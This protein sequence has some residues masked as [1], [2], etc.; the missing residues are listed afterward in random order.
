MKITRL[1]WA[2]LFAMSFSCAEQPSGSKD[3]MDL[4]AADLGRV[5]VGKSAPDFTLLSKDNEAVTL[6]SFEGKNNVV[7]VFYRGYW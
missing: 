5:S 1:F 7:L 3:G 2:L 4:P 6:S